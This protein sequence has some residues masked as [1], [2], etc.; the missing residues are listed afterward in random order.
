MIACRLSPSRLHLS[1]AF[2]RN[3]HSFGRVFARMPTKYPVPLVSQAKGQHSATVIFLHGLG[4][5]AYGWTA[6]VQ[7]WRASGRLDHVKAILPNAPSMPI[8]LVGAP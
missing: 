3:K 6:V 2:I 1:R 5:Q 7:E 4:D 8:T